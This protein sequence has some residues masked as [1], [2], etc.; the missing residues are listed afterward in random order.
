MEQSLQEFVVKAIA[1]LQ[2][3]NR[4]RECLEL[5]RKFYRL[6]LVCESLPPNVADV[7]TLLFK[8][9][10]DPKAPKKMAA[11]FVYVLS[12]LARGELG[13]LKVDLSQTYE[14]WLAAFLGPLLIQTGSGT[15]LRKNLST[16][17]QWTAQIPDSSEDPPLVLMQTSFRAMCDLA[18]HERPVKKLLFFFSFFFFLFF[19]F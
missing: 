11:V 7:R 3:R 2:S 6:A 15:S 14:P 19:F 10:Q 16:I 13:F 1:M 5:M 8:A 18:R 12:L 17:A 9:I 4:G